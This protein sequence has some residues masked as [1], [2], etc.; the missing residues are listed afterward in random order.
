MD[1]IRLVAGLLCGTGLFAWF[2][3][4]GCRGSFWKTDQCMD[5][6]LDNNASAKPLP[7]ISVLIPARN[8]SDVIQKT[9]PALLEQ[10]YTGEYHIYLIDDC[11][12][13]KT[14]EVARKL[15]Q[16]SS[17]GHRLTVVSGKPLPPQWTG[18]LWA[19]QQGIE[20]SMERR[21]RYFL[22]T[23]ADI[24]HPPFCVTRLVGKATRQHL[25]MISLMVKL[26]CYQIFFP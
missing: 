18:K 8:E 12:T 6:L 16:S 23:D 26:Q 10:H 14:G 4:I 19:L 13:D 5:N 17:Q 3:L 24:L 9:L 2:Y 7:S 15:A 11:S 21:P 25:S 22:F 1:I 20:A